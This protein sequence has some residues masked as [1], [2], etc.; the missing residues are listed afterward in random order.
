[1]RELVEE[2]GVTP[3]QFF[4]FLRVVVTGQKV[5][6]PLFES[7]E[8]IGKQKVLERI[9]NAITMLENTN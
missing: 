2:L 9:R 1:M 3:G 5:S 6:P 8:I 7:M 4:G